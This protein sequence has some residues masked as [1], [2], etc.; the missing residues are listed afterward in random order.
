MNA[1]TQESKSQ[2]TPVDNNNSFTKTVHIYTKRLILLFSK[3]Y[4]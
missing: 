3:K 4:F 2:L 1:T